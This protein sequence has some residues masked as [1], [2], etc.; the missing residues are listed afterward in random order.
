MSREEAIRGLQQIQKKAEGHFDGYGYDVFLFQCE[1]DA[2]QE[3]I[4]HLLSDEVFARLA[5]SIEASD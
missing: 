5:E 3:A 4:T 1:Y 2:I